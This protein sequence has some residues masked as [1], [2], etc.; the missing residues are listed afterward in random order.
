[1]SHNRF[2]A[3]RFL[4]SRGGA[5]KKTNK[6]WYKNVARDVVRCCMPPDFK[7]YADDGIRSF[8]RNKIRLYTNLKNTNKFNSNNTLFSIWFIFILLLFMLLS[9]PPSLLSCSLFFLRLVNCV[10]YHFPIFS[11]IV[12]SLWLCFIYFDLFSFIL[13]NY[14]DFL[15]L[16]DLFDRFDSSILFLLIF[17][18]F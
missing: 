6:G 15:V 2:V 11:L 9:S 14:F 18:T 3:L 5:N 13:L 12:F 17:T 4:R 16:F 1:M 8:D 7:Y 10:T